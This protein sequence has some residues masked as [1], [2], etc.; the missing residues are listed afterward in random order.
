LAAIQG[1]DVSGCAK[2]PAG[3]ACEV[4]CPNGLIGDAALFHCFPKRADGG[5]T[6]VGLRDAPQCIKP[7][8]LEFKAGTSTPLM[9]G[10]GKCLVCARA[11]SACT[12]AA[13]GCTKFQLA[14]GQGKALL[15]KNGRQCVDMFGG[16]KF[17]QWGCNGG[18]NQKF[19]PT[20]TQGEICAKS[21][22]GTLCL[23][24]PG[25][26]PAAPIVPGLSL[27]GPALEAAKK[28][29][30]G[31]PTFLRRTLSAQ[32]CK[33]KMEADVPA[34][35]W[36][37]LEKQG[38]SAMK[39]V[40][41]TFPV[42]SNQ[43]KLLHELRVAVGK[44]K[45]DNLKMMPFAIALS[46]L[47]RFKKIDDAAEHPHPSFEINGYDYLKHQLAEAKQAMIN[48]EHCNIQ[49][50]ECRDLKKCCGPPN[51]WKFKWPRDPSPSVKEWAQWWST[52]VSEH[53]KK[54]WWNPLS[55]TPWIFSLY[56]WPSPLKECE[57]VHEKLIGGKPIENGGKW[58]KYDAKFHRNVCSR[59]HPEIHPDG[60]GG[61]AVYGGVCGRMA[62][63]EWRKTGCMGA[64]ATM[65]SEPGHCA[66]FKYVPGGGD[67]TTLS[68][69]NR[70]CLVCSQRGKR[71][72]FSNRK[73]GCSKFLVTDGKAKNELD[74]HKVL[75][76]D[77]TGQCVDLHARNTPGLWG[78]NGGANQKF[79]E[80]GELD[81]TCKSYRGPLTV[82]RAPRDPAAAKKTSWRI[83][84]IHEIKCTQNNCHFNSATANL[85]ASSTA[86]TSKVHKEAAIAA[87]ESFNEQ[88]QDGVWPVA[89]DEARLA[90]SV[91][92]ALR[93]QSPTLA[94]N[95][96]GWA[97]DRNPAVHEI[98]EA[99]SEH[100]TQLYRHRS[101]AREKLASRQWFRK[102]VTA[103]PQL[104]ASVGVHEAEALA[105][106][107]AERFTQER[108]LNDKYQNFFTKYP[109]L[110]KRLVA[111]AC[112]ILNASDGNVRSLNGTLA[113]LVGCQGSNRDTVREIVA[114]AEDSDQKGNTA[115]EAFGEKL[116]ELKVR[117]AAGEQAAF[118]ILHELL[119]DLTVGYVNV[120]SETFFAEHGRV[121]LRGPYAVVLKL[122]GLFLDEGN[123]TE[124]L[125][126]TKTIVQSPEMQE[127]VTRIRCDN[128][129][130]YD[131]FVEWVPSHRATLKHAHVSEN[132]AVDDDVDGTKP[133][134]EAGLEVVEQLR[135]DQDDEAE[136]GEETWSADYHKSQS[137]DDDRHH[138]DT[139]LQT[140][141]NLGGADQ[142]SPDDVEF[143]EIKTSDV[144]EE[145]PKVILADPHELRLLQQQ[146]EDA[147]AE[148]VDDLES[149][150]SEKF[151]TTTR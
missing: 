94:E 25:A 75:V 102:Q 74:M 4:K 14:A 32:I 133:L 8:V 70:G 86:T 61:I 132:A 18:D 130:I 128:Q 100:F 26:F 24:K 42:N 41:S 93:A 45:F 135:L 122:A 131:N 85:D 40:F 88:E 103:L 77:D 98:W 50:N 145:Q 54:L 117:L 115:S 108:L 64:P 123:R 99:A 30:S 84:G 114:A 71:C 104:D 56:V 151:W 126:N 20:A 118:G 72:S 121:L 138:I 149:R 140:L 110:K 39:S 87:T 69:G 90:A 125:N 37:W 107:A 147:L 113:S 97:L 57:W 33:A 2:V 62:Q 21:H 91:A 141:L 15:L 43:L 34:E 134:D 79:V 47:N 46:Y 127:Q 51:T 19:T 58:Y 68:V 80:E 10:P 53:G 92:V 5:K 17:G 119:N 65:K 137:A 96:L 63:L 150:F 139:L 7:S 136:L 95:A 22:R 44:E 48:G 144:L 143:L 31:R 148:C 112:S 105:M 38:A 13:S 12:V 129:E 67:K 83:K 23:R 89:H 146:A 6:P 36:S 76:H 9:V 27:M 124:L 106:A 29:L 120:R 66:G 109:V 52:K 142:G 49:S 28:G 78:C 81:L 11:H 101:S 3:G 35:F 111:A 1:H 116:D 60:L 82:T 73:V 55:D 16:P 59:G